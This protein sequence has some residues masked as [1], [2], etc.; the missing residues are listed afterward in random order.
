MAN[1]LEIQKEETLKAQVFR[2]Y[3]DKVK[4][5]YEPNIGNIDFIVTDVKLAASGLFKAHYFWAEAK[6]GEVDEISMMT[7]LVLTCKKTYDSGEFMPPPFIGCFDGKKIAFLPFHD[8]LPLFTENDINWNAA[9][10]NYLSDDFIK[11]RK[12]I[13]KLLAKNFTVYDFDDD[14]AEIKNFIKRNFIPG[15][16]STKSPITKNN[17]PHI[18]N[19]WVKEVKSTINISADRWQKY[20]K[21]GILDCDFFRA[22]MMS[23]GG[24]TIT[25]KLKIILENDKYKLQKDIEGELFKTEIDFAD[26]GMAYRRFWNKYERPPVQEYQQYIIDRRDLLVPQNI[27]EIKGSFFTPAIWVE[28]SQ[29]YIERALDIDWQDEYVIWDCAAGT[30]NLLAGLTNKY[31]VWASTIDQPDVDTIHALIDEGFNLLHDHVFQFDF[32]ND[33][34]DKLPKGLKETIDDNEKRKKLFIYINPPYAEGDNRRG[35]GRT[36]VAVSKI[37]NKYARS[38]GYTKREI[39]IQ[40]LARIDFEL[41][42]CKIGE[43]STLTGLTGPKFI[44]FRNFFKA[45]IKM[46]F[47]VPAYTFDNVTGKFPIGFKVWDTDNKTMFHKIIADIYNGEGVNIGKKTIFAYTNEKVIND[48][49]TTFIDDTKE[50]MGNIIGVANDFQHQNTVCIERPNKPWNHQYQ[51][52]I[53]QDTFIESCI[54]YTVRKC[55]EHTWINH[56]DQFLFPDIEKLHNDTIFAT[57]CLLYTL[58][59][60]KNFFSSKDGVNHWIPFTEEEVN[61]RDTFE[62]NFMSNYLKGKTFSHEAKNVFDSGLELWK[63]YHAKIKNNRTVSVNASFYDIREYFQGRNANGNMNTS[64]MDEQYN[65]LIKVLRNNL[66][67]LAQKI[68]PKIYEYGFLKE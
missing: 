48:W 19:R 36:G 62:S 9:P 42:G 65:R 10:S 34:F 6:K 2:D 12:K 66:K 37:Q 61:A 27:R 22:D 53:N 58:F 13:T 25:E 35:E 11:A 59:G 8:I 31:K 44:D 33:S 14:T 63:Y 41:G 28:K 54:Y 38:M 64:S 46:F 30:G 32:L 60:S 1:Y 23:Q 29:E 67:L 4:F 5:A 52:Q 20:K 47:I 26:G 15:M 50:S 24:N 43:F 18:Y 68:E 51:W 40:F 45:S 21:E 57:N 39:Y 16:A 17:F 49:T 56:N 3:F 55:I 7:Q